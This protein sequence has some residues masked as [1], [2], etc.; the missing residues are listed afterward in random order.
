[1]FGKDRCPDFFLSI[2]HRITNLP[3]YLD[4]IHTVVMTD[5]LLDAMIAVIAMVV[6]QV[7]NEIKLKEIILPHLHV[8]EFLA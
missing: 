7:G 1:M 4:V 5:V 3:F 2:F 6:N 8:L